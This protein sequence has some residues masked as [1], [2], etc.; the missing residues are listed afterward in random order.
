MAHPPIP[1]TLDGREL[2][3][4]FA[5]LRLLQRTPV[6]PDGIEWITTD[7]HTIVPLDDAG[8]DALC[9]RLNCETV[10]APQEGIR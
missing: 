8:I 5:G 9:E 7:R 6:L 2:A 4:I 10:P 1:V 3:A